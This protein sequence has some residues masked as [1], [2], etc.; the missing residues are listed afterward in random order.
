M[1]STQTITESLKVASTM[2]RNAN[3]K[4]NIPEIQR[5]TMEFERENDI[6]EQRQEIMDDAI[7]EATMGDEDEEE[8]E[9]EV[10][11][12]CDELNIQ[13]GQSVSQTPEQ[14]FQ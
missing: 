3:R 12:I 2:M 1:R 4:M 11:K 13:L 5:M 7:D 9:A 14:S 10:S 6:M 8:A